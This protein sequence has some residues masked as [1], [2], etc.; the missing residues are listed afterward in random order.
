VDD[1]RRA[2][3]KPPAQ[4]VGMAESNVMEIRGKS[5]GKLGTPF[6]WHRQRLNGYVRSP[7]STPG[8]YAPLGEHPCVGGLFQSK[9][10]PAGVNQRPSPLIVRMKLPAQNVATW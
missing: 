3:T 10:K 5:P 7:G 9:K 8:T 4:P 1:A 6:D 2:P